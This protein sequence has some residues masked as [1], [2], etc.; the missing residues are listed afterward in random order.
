MRNKFVVRSFLII[1]IL[2]VGGSLYSLP[3]YVSKPGKAMELSPIIEVENGYEE[4][5]S[6]MLT[7]VRMG[8]ANIYSYL[9]AK[10]NKYEEIYP[11]EVIRSEDETDEEYNVRQLHLMASSKL[12][13]I[14]VAYEAA[15]IPV[16]YQYRGVYV[17]NVIPGMPAEDKLQAG[18][19][20]FKVDGKEFKSSTE[21]VSYVENLGDGQEIALTFE[22]N[23]VVKEVTIPLKEFEDRPGKV[24]VGIGLVDDKEIIVDP[25]VEVETEKIGGPSAGT[26]FALEI[27]NQL[28]VDDYT[29]GYEIAG[30][31]TIDPEGN[32]GPIG[33]IEQKIIA[34]DKAG[35]E[36]FFA[37]NE[38]GAADSNY[39][40]AS[41]TAKDIGTNMKIV[42][43]D[44]FSEAIAYL[45]SLRAK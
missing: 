15:G 19:R 40:A 30:T 23:Q 38:G 25:V 44:T 31:G 6:F 43:I 22:R 11:V 39:R 42:P 29:K 9:L 12:A 32:V 41:A 35:A 26:M 4:K 14:E 2:L 24:G 7:T 21:F 45:Q 5:G 16:N 33:G 17:L 18:D 34:A 10:L 28:T 13:A 36:I 20:V 27:Y 8:K 37:P 1:V 3:Y